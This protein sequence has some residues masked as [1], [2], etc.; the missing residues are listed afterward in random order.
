MNVMRRRARGTQSYPQ[1][2]YIQKSRPSARRLEACR[3]LT[4]GV[5][6]REKRFTNPL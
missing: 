2:L 1:T 4:E 5:D 6:L 3:R